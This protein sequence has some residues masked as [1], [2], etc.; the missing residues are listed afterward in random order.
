MPPA[1]ENMVETAFSDGD[2]SAD[3]IDDTELNQDENEPAGGKLR[4]P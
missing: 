3:E 1:E 2:W 4:L